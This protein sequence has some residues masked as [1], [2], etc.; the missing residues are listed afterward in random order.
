MHN[1]S[2]S[3]SVFCSNKSNKLRKIMEIFYLDVSAD[4]LQI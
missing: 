3:N 2:V 1:G 4:V